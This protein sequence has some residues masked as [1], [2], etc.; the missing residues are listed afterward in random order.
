MLMLVDMSTQIANEGFDASPEQM[1]TR[2]VALSLLVDL[3]L[4]YPE[5]F[6]RRGPEVERR[7]AENMLAVL[8]RATRDNLKTMSSLAINLMCYLLDKFA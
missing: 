7:A 3:W 5:R 1:Q 6:Q 4:A 8:K 2:Q